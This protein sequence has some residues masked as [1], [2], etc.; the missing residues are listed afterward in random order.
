MGL[1]GECGIGL[2]FAM[3][4][5]KD[6]VVHCDLL[7]PAYLA[8]RRNCDRDVQKKMERPE[9]YSISQRTAAVE[10]DAENVSECG[11][12]FPSF[13]DA[14]L[15]HGVPHVAIDDEPLFGVVTLTHDEWF[16]A[17]GLC[18][19]GGKANGAEGSDSVGW[20]WLAHTLSLRFSTD[21]M[22]VMASWRS[23]LL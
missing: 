2:S 11:V 18:P 8:E 1:A 16:A 17:S 23:S 3:S 20:L 5:F 4:S 15:H 21:M 10:S 6:I 7:F 19:F 14:D 9:G 22:N 13:E 12:L